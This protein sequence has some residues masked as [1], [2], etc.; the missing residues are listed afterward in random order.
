MVH[1]RNEDAAR[2]PKD[3]QRTPPSLFRKLDDIYHFDLDAAATKQNALCPLYYT[4]E[5]DA[6]KQDWNK[7]LGGSHVNVFCN[8][9][10]SDGNVEAFTRKGYY[11]SLTGNATVVLL[12]SSDMS[13]AWFDY[14]MFASE[15]IR[16]KGRVSFN[17]EDGVPI[18]GSPAFGSLVVVFDSEARKLNGRRIRVSAM[19]W[20]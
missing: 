17:H 1:P 4:K 7:A 18:K 6:L 12:V 15:W 9:P 20:K 10:Y 11:E 5:I 8:P 2:T 16:I 14:C 19:G 13:P 3:E